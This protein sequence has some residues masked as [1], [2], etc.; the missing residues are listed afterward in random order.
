M[1]KILQKSMQQ[2]NEAMFKILKSITSDG[3]SIGDGLA[4]LASAFAG[5]PNNNLQQ[6][7]PANTYLTYQNMSGQTESTKF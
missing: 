5:K 1:V 6:N 7:Y 2:S 4:L 3:K